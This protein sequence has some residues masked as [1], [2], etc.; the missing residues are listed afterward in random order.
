MVEKRLKIISLNNIFEFLNKNRTFIYVDVGGGS[1]EF[2][3][4]LNGKRKKI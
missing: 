4:I 2:S 1:T 3:I